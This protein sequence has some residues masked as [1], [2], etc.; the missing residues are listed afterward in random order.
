[1]VYRIIESKCISYGECENKC[2][3]ACI[4]INE[5]FNMGI[6]ESICTGCGICPSE[7]IVPMA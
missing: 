7:G 4:S 1:M 3:K 6:D 2:L 5:D